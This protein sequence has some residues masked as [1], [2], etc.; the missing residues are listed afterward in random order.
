M[1]SE[2]FFPLTPS[3]NNFPQQFPADRHDRMYETCSTIVA[4]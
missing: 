4:R 2:T 1:D 3:K